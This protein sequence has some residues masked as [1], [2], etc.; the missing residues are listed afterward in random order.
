MSRTGRPP[1]AD[2]PV[3]WKLTLP[4]SLVAEFEILTADPLTGHQVKGARSRIAASLLR[5][6]LEACATG[7]R[8]M[9]ITDALAVLHR[10][11][12]NDG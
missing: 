7:A 5:G 11:A 8:T 1:H 10:Y 2:R 6:F 9:D 3:N 12:Q 4:E